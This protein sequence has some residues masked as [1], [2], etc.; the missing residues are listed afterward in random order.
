MIDHQPLFCLD[1]IQDPRMI[2]QQVDESMEFKSEGRVHL[3]LEEHGDIES[4]PGPRR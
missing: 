2:L 3:H 4:N 1:V